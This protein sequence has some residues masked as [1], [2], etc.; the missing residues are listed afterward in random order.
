MIALVAAKLGLRKLMP[1]RDD[2]VP[3]AAVVSVSTLLA[4][5]NQGLVVVHSGE[6]TLP[7]LLNT[8]AC[9]VPVTPSMLVELFQARLPEKP[10]VFGPVI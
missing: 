5:L 4:T 9:T 3:A 10:V 8:E 6:L 7:V 2:V 1:T